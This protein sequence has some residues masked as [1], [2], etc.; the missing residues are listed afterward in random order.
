MLHRHGDNVEPDDDGDEQVK[1]MAG[2]HLVD[3]Q[4]GGGVVRVVRFTLSFCGKGGVMG[5]G[6]REWRKEEEEEGEG[7]IK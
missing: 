6:H 5:A 7:V 1:V 3:E 4:A 2:A